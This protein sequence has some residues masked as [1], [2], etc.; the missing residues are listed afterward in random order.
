MAML[1]SELAQFLGMD[2]GAIPAIKPTHSDENILEQDSVS[3]F[4][5]FV[6]PKRTRGGGGGG[7]EE[8][9]NRRSAD[10]VAEH[11]RSSLFAVSDTEEA[12]GDTDDGTAAEEGEVGEAGEAATTE[13]ASRRHAVA[14]TAPVP[15]PPEC[16][17]GA[18]PFAAETRRLS[19]SLGTTTAAAVR[20]GSGGSGGGLGSSVPIHV[21]SARVRTAPAEG[22][23]GVRSDGGS[24]WVLEGESSWV[25]SPS[26]QQP[27]MVEGQTLKSPVN[28]GTRHNS[29]T[30]LM[31]VAPHS[32]LS[33]QMLGDSE[34]T[35][36]AAATVSAFAVRAA[37]Y[38]SLAH[39]QLSVFFG[40]RLAFG[41]QTEESR[42]WHP[43]LKTWS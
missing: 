32:E 39:F 18:S 37:L 20:F 38:I 16:A 1:R 12:E 27:V 3:V 35:T 2:A 10:L 5:R 15:L 24:G 14:S 30:D 42:R 33:V 36:T 8:D 13:E 22:S 29:N 26:V 23:R 28:M 19:G 43:T 31:G 21:W 11:S 17:G 25:H 34:A 4:G 41:G 6:P 9:E 40:R 7:G